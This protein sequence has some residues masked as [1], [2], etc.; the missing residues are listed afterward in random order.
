MQLIESLYAVFSVT[1][2][3]GGLAMVVMAMRAYQRTSRRSMLHL[4]IGF[5]LIVAAAVATTVSAFLG[6]FE[7]SRRLLTVNYL[8]TTMGYL[9][10]ISSI[11]VV[12]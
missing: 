4:S 9:F 3:G 10:V 11:T 6:D 5:T 2:A 8:I 12:E 7:N 1:L